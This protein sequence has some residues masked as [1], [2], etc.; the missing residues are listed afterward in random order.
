MGDIF[1]ELIFM[2]DVLVAHE[3]S[4]R[5]FNPLWCQVRNTHLTTTVDLIKKSEP[6]ILNIRRYTARTPYN[7]KRQNLN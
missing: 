4:A 3:K 6:Y 7:L 1:A 2:S 5:I